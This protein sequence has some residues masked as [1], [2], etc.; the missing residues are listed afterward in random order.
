MATVVCGS[1]KTAKDVVRISF[2]D[3]WRT[4]TEYQTDN[5]SV[6]SWL[7]GIVRNQATAARE[8]DDMWGRQRYRP[9]S[10]STDSERAPIDDDVG[11]DAADAIAL[12][13]ADAPREQRELVALAFFGELSPTEISDQLGLS[14]G[15]VRGR[16]RLGLNKLRERD[17]THQA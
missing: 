14:E 12:L 2:A 7:F 4:C 8:G 16:M 6:H 5:G 15:V 13:L 11:T 9:E 17:F 10:T 3:A 1:S